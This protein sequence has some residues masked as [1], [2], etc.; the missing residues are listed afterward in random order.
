MLVIMAS[1]YFMPHRYAMQRQLV[2]YFTPELFN[3]SSNLRLTLSHSFVR[4]ITV[5]SSA[6]RTAV[7]VSIYNI[8]V[9]NIL[10]WS[11]SDCTFQTAFQTTL[12][13]T[14]T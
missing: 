3:A 10:L 1:L 7:S 2:A 14:R 8:I 11:F 13:H 4:V 12:T 6:V 9:Q 5:F